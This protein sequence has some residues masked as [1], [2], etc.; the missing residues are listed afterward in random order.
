MFVYILF[1]CFVSCLILY[2]NTYISPMK[3]SFFVSFCVKQILCGKNEGRTFQNNIC[4][5]FL[6]YRLFGIHLNGYI[7][8][9]AKDV[10]FYSAQLTPH[11]H[12]IN[13]LFW[14]SVY[15]EKCYVW[16]KKMAECLVRSIFLKLNK[17]FKSQSFSQN[18]LS[19][20]TIVFE[21]LDGENYQILSFQFFVKKK[22]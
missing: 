8:C 2:M 9:D 15:K 19:Q 13:F 10:R 12:M 16:S 5:I 17:F 14:V 6:V 21:V 18:I 22:S 3:S 7:V 1:F 20:T 11:T 4:T